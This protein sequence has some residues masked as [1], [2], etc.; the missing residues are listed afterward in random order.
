MGVMSA[1]PQVGG[2]PAGVAN[3]GSVLGGFL[4]IDL[5]LKFGWRGSPG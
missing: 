2:D 3:F 1:L 4:C 5:R